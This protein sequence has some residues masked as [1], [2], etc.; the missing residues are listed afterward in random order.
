MLNRLVVKFDGQAALFSR[1]PTRQISELWVLGD[2]DNLKQQLNASGAAAF[3]WNNPVTSP[4]SNG[5][6]ARRSP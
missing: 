4:A 1:P 2:V 3:S 6:H 5:E